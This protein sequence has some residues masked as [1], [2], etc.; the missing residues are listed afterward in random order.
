MDKIVVF[1]S[2]FG[3][4]TVLK[5]LEKL[6]PDEEYIYYGDSA[7][8]PYGDKSHD[9][10]LKLDSAICTKVSEAYPVKCFVI[11]CNT[12]TSEVWDELTA[13]YSDYDFVG[14]EPALAWAAEENPGK[15]IL[16]LATTAT[17]NGKR[18]KA[19]YEEYKDRAEI[20]L[21]A[22][23]GI[24]PFVESCSTGEQEFRDYLEELLGPYI[25][26]TDCVVLGCTHFPF[27]KNEIREVL[28]DHI[29]FYDAAVTV[30]QNVRRL[31]EEKQK[32]APAVSGKTGQQ[33][34]PAVRK[35]N[36]IYLNSDPSKVEM[37]AQLLG[38]YSGIREI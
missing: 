15:R 28:G 1:D 14:I 26:K 4:L 31:L 30:A 6:L 3:G 16:V 36:V 22:A 7:N 10:L 27:V 20:T 38:V 11:A 37:E 13:K 18:L 24:V 9:E 12:T 35:E 21:L 25:G 34:T 32:L 5:E 17:I 33:G 29:R 23:P 8:A 2:G 19:R